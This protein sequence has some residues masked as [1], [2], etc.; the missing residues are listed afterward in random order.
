MRD[1]WGFTTRFP[2]GSPLLLRVFCCLSLT[3]SDEALKG[4][5]DLEVSYHTTWSWG[6][7]L[8][9]LAVSL[10]LPDLLVSLFLVIRDSTKFL[11]GIPWDCKKCT[12]NSCPCLL[13][14]LSNDKEGLVEFSSLISDVLTLMSVFNNILWGKRYQFNGNIRKVSTVIHI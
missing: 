3:F 5:E 4:S 1:A 13:V 9:F 14:L 12:R 11:D 10:S 2:R 8:I 6:L 7:V